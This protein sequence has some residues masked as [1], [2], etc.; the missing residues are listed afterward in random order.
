MSITIDERREKRAIDRM[1]DARRMIVT[2][3]DALVEAAEEYQAAIRPSDLFEGD[4]A[5]WDAA[6]VTQF[7]KRKDVQ[8]V[9]RLTERGIIPCVRIPSVNGE[10]EDI[11]YVPSII[12]QWAI[13]Q[14]RAA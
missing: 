7:L 1:H 4:E 12:R 8:T 2:A 14:S 10:R 5:L 6:D 3:L 11:R 9:R 13:D